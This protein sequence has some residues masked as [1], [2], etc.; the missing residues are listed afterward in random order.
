M[1]YG[2][3]DQ[4]SDDEVPIICL[5]VASP[6]RPS[7][8]AAAASPAS[9][10]GAVPIPRSSLGPTLDLWSDDAAIPF[11]GPILLLL[12][13][14]VSI[15]GA[16]LRSHFCVSMYVRAE[17]DI[18]HGTGATSSLMFAGEAAS[19]AGRGGEGTCRQG[20]GRSSSLTR[21]KAP[22]V[23]VLGKYSRTCGT[24]TAASGTQR[25]NLG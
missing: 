24:G 20:K 22:D 16:V 21:P 5:H 1:V 2:A 25:E 15:V 10:D 23:Q 4:V 6:P 11:V 7:A 17:R 3:P 13:Q 12:G 18:K 19:W 14:Y 8:C 9:S